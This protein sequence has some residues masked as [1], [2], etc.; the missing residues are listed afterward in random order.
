MSP[1]EIEDLPARGRRIVLDTLR[2][3]RD[4]RRDHHACTVGEIARV[5]KVPKNTVMHR[6][7]QLR[8]RNL[9]QWTE[10]PGSVCLTMRGGKVL[11]WLE[12]GG[13]SDG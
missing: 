12:R 1:R 4:V 6:L 13:D 9:V 11:A 10:L 8:E 3:I 2:S 5:S 7:N